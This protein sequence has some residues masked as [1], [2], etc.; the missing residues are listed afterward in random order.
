MDGRYD[1]SRCAASAQPSSCLG[2]KFLLAEI[3]APWYDSSVSSGM[4]VG[5]FTSRRGENRKNVCLSRQFRER[6]TNEKTYVHT[7]RFRFRDRSQLC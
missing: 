1:A 2:T 4:N 5:S 3:V 7:G 6:M